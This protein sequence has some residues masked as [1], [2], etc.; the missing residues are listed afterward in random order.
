MAE[1]RKPGGTSSGPGETPEN[2]RA[3]ENAVRALKASVDSANESFSKQLEIVSKLRESI[4]QMSTSL[5][6]AGDASKK[7]FSPEE[8]QKMYEAIGKVKNQTDS[9]GKS[10]KTLEKEMKDKLSKG[11][12]IAGSALTGLVQGFKNF[13][14]IGTFVFDSVT[15]IGEALF[16]L[17]AAIISIPFQFFDDLIQKAQKGGGGN[18]LAQAYEAVR[19]QFGAFSSVSSHAVISVSKSMQGFKDSGLGVY[20]V[21]GNLAQRM[22]EVRELATAMGPIFA[23]T[24]DQFEKAGGAIMGFQK[25]LGLSN[26]QMQALG[27]RAVSRGQDIVDVQVEMTKQA[28][29]MAKAFGLDAKIISRDMGKALQDV[30]HFGHMSSKELAVAVTYANKLGVSIDKLT[31][32]MDKFDT[33]D[34]SAES[35]SNLNAQ[36]GLNLDAMQLMAAQ[37]PAEKMSLLQKAFN[38][39]GKDLT[40]LSYQERKFIAQQ[41]G[42]EMATLDVAMAQ[43][44]ATV[45]LSDMER[46]GADAEKKTITQADALKSLADAIERLTPSGSSAGGGFLNHL[47]EGFRMGLESSGP[48][49]RVMMNIRK[50]LW[51]TQWEGVSLGKKFVEVFPGVKKLL[52]G[53]GDMFDPKNFQAFFKEINGIIDAFV[54][55]DLKSFDELMMK[56]KD[57]FFGF[58]SKEET[59]GKKFLNGLKEF[60]RAIVKGIVGIG[61]WAFSEM[62]SLFGDFIAEML[63]P[64]PAASEIVSGL[65]SFGLSVI[66]GIVDLGKWAFKQFSSLYDA[67]I[68]EL[69]N[70]GAATIAIKSSLTSA[71]QSVGDFITNIFK[72]FAVNVVKSITGLL[73]SEGESSDQKSEIEKFLSDIFKPIWSALR[74]LYKDPG[75]RTALKD[76]GTSLIAAIKDALWWVAVNMPWEGWVVLFGPAVFNIVSAIGG[77]F[78]K[79]KMQQAIS[80]SVTKSV[81]QSITKAS[82]D[83]DTSSTN[84]DISRSGQSAGAAVSKGFMGKFSSGMK[85][86]GTAGLIYEGAQI[87]YEV[88][89]LGI[90]FVFDKIQ[91]SNKEA[92][93][94]LAASQNEAI[95]KISNVKDLGRRQLEAEKKKDEVWKQ[96]QEKYELKE[97][98]LLAVKT[99]V[100]VSD[101]DEMKAQEYMNMQS[102]INGSKRLAADA[103]KGLTPE[104]KKAQ[105]EKNEAIAAAQKKALEEIGPVTFEN[106]AE[107]FGKIDELAKK[108]LSPDF[109]LQETMDKLRE[110]LKG[111]NFSLFESAAQENKAKESAVAINM[112]SSIFGNLS[113][114]VD[115]MVEISKKITEIGTD[116]D[117]KTPAGILAQKSPHMQRAIEGLINAFTTG[118]VT[119]ENADAAKSAAIAVSTMSQFL[120]PMGKN[121]QILSDTLSNMNFE[122]FISNIGAGSD[123]NKGLRGALGNLIQVFHGHEDVFGET[124][125]GI[126]KSQAVITKTMGVLKSFT[127]LMFEIDNTDLSTTVVSSFGAAINGMTKDL[128]FNSQSMEIIQKLASDMSI[129]GA[130]MES[131]ERVFA[132]TKSVTQKSVQNAIS[133][134]EQMVSSTQ[135]LDN[136]LARGSSIDIQSNLQQLAA[137]SGLGDAG[138]YTVKSKE[139]LINVNFVINFKTSDV[140]KS[141]VETH[142][143]LIRDRINTL[144]KGVIT[145]TAGTQSDKDQTA[146]GA[147]DWYIHAG[148]GNDIRHSNVT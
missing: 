55:G 126:E 56:L 110:K 144:T 24:A 66:N 49:L 36:F 37:S 19:K 118:K 28:G 147:S 51:D 74:D 34:S 17:G 4:G 22:N 94:K 46:V 41:T 106:A 25:G 50:S 58:F 128:T 71:A 21:F 53:L 95:S 116:S 16:N 69:K 64:G 146:A 32:L 42:L 130:Y 138:V 43:K 38:Q 20:R 45:S 63:D 65:K 44:N 133:A 114:T 76:F 115:G 13:T 67:L 139:I 98:G 145:A 11:F 120:Y 29:A 72:P 124:V 78:L 9:A 109:N 140:E 111:I 26:E 117:D 90:D 62:Q 2:V 88:G 1:D 8:W 112:I 73:K 141:I 92:V 61:K 89:K 105:Q 104:F 18:E 134:V 125:V 142:N 48:F 70:P 131:I 83:L 86:L 96:I 40:K 132:G 79:A 100:E 10:A 33:F 113:K 121:L 127:T 84:G 12:T 123:P 102:L 30:A 93:E 97:G 68:S 5:N 143:S 39:T 3:T 148:G 59:G 60:G 31:G 99:G 23:K 135:Q 137:S 6:M 136:A 82:S 52:D 129:F 80:S 101:L 103:A 14:S 47:L 87:L 119:Y 77:M 75:L 27:T 7:A 54:K 81:Q 107:K 91:A 122:A 57:G 108:I 15:S 35:V 85:L